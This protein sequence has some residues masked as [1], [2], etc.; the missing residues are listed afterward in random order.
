MLVAAV[1]GVI[2]RREAREAHGLGRAAAD[3]RSR[4]V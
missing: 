1:M 2:C 4:R 3:V